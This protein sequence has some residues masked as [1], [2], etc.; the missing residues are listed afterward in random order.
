M[1][2]KPQFLLFMGKKRSNCVFVLHLYCICIHHG[3]DNGIYLYFSVSMYSARLNME[4]RMSHY[5]AFIV[6]GYM[7]GYWIT[8]ELCILFLRN[9][10]ILSIIAVLFILSPTVDGVPFSSHHT[11]LVVFGVFFFLI[12]TTLVKVRSYVLMSYPGDFFIMSPFPC[13]VGHLIDF[14][15]IPGKVYHPISSQVF[16]FCYRFF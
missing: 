9:L 14:W 6:F 1:S 8:N 2:Q 7:W 5:T 16:Y 15:E 12:V 13:T 10:R 11:V 4:V 3:G